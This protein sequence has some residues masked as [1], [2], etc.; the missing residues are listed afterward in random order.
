MT[1]KNKQKKTSPTRQAELKKMLEDR[2]REL[3]SEIH[4][5]PIK[6]S[7]DVMDPVESTAV[8]IEEDIEL[9]IRQMRAETIHKINNA[10]QRLHDGTYGNCSDCG[11]EVSE[12]RLR[13]LMFA[14]RCKN[15]QETDEARRR[16]AHSSKS[17]VLPG[18]LF[19]IAKDD[20]KA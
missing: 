13:A 12:V 5:H 10:L 14:T 2:R 9:A 3:M 6:K 8:D 17:Y 4:G 19:D 7:G 11:N 1:P 18:D 15:C 16:A 20:A